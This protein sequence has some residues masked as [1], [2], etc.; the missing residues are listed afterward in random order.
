MIEI[1][2]DES[3]K[4]LK[5][6]EKKYIVETLDRSMTEVENFR[7]ATA[8]VV[9]RD[10][11]DCETAETEW[12]MRLDYAKK[13]G[14]FIL[15]NEDQANI[16]VYDERIGKIPYSYT[17]TNPDYKIPEEAE[18]I[19]IESDETFILTLA[20][21]RYI[22]VWIRIENDYKNYLKNGDIDKEI[23]MYVNRFKEKAQNIPLHERLC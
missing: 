5:N 9:G 6:P 22:K 18:L 4:Q 13:I 19:R 20:K 10:Y 7:E 14:L 8:V 17:E 1:I 12:L 11:I 23:E 2:K 21:L 15:A 16:I 3:G